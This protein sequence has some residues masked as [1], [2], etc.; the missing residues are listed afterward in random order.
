[1]AGLIVVLLAA[2]AGVA[3]ADAKPE[4]RAGVSRLDI[5][6]EKPIWMSG[7]AART[8]PSDGALHPLWAK[9]LAIEDRKGYR[10]VIVTT[11]LIGL[12]RVIT[13]EVAARL[14]KRHNLRRAQIV[15]NASHTHTGPVVRPNLMT[16]YFL[17]PDE[18]QVVEEYARKLTGDLFQVAS[19]ALG[20]LK[21]AE[22]RFGQGTAGF[23]NNRRNAKGPTDHSVPVIEVVADGKP[24]A[25][26]FGYSCHN[27]THVAEDTKLS[28]DYTGFAQ[29]ELEAKYPGATAL[30]ITLCGADQNPNP[31]GKTEYA[32]DH[33]KELAESV[34][35]VLSG[36]MVTLHA[37]LK[38]TYSNVDLA[39]ALH[40]RDQF[41]E[42]AKS[43]DK[44][45]ASR[46]REMLAK[47]DEGRP[48]R[49]TPYP[50]QA[51]RFGKDLTLVALGG[52]VVVDYALRIK[53]HYDKERVVVAGYSNDVMC[54]IPSLRILKEGGYEGLT[55][56]IYY[57]Q[58]GPFAADVEDRIWLAVAKAMKRVGAKQ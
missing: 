2:M 20:D 16:M 40:T 34:G 48:V 19:A 45:K 31:R 6:P 36:Q 28:G 5:T 54:Y 10:L 1:M 58:P 32:Q 9:G 23:G 15:F 52:E 44:F 50:V 43:A 42:E 26:L 12:P 37:P 7:Y 49:S 13:D 22:L 11:D 38:S 18:K 24:K 39:F 3:Y 8:K 25:I 41:E 33:G 4:F 17:S 56:M 29:I 35:K 57:G 30:F 21:P 27:T 51:I 47:Y 53:R 46:A 14:E 55:S